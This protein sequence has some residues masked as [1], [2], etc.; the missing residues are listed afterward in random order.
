MNRE[1]DEALFKAELYGLIG[2]AARAL[3]WIDAFLVGHIDDQNGEA[4]KELDPFIDKIRFFHLDLEKELREINK[5][6]EGKEAEYLNKKWIL[7]SYKTLEREITENIEKQ[8]Q[9]VNRISDDTSLGYETYTLLDKERK[10]I[11]K[12]N[13]LIKKSVENLEKAIKVHYKN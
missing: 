11:L 1:L 6:L 12:A 4:R 13:E 7:A 5:K 10:R 2:A 9:T 8:S 3:E